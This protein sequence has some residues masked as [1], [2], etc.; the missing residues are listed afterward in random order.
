MSLSWLL[1]GSFKHTFDIV[2]FSRSLCCA[3][4]SQELYFITV[5]VLCQPLFKTFFKVFWSFLTS[6]K[7]SRALRF[8]T[9]LSLY[10]YHLHLSTLFFDF[11]WKNLKNQVPSYL[12]IIIKFSLN[13]EQSRAKTRSK[14]K[15][16]NFYKK[17]L[18]TGTNCVKI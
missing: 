5:P 9:A 13:S 11:F 12:Y 1:K 4:L 2:Q 8:W 15:V 6:S 18:T 16:Y 3:L 10:T 14:I 7:H 17:V